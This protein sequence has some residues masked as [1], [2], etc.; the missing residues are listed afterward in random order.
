VELL[1]RKPDYN[2]SFAREDLFF[3]ANKAFIN[4]F[5]EGLARAGVPA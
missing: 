1:A 2:C 3:C 4:R 5:G